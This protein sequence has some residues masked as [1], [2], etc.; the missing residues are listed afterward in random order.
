M[1][2]A[3]IFERE[4]GTRI[5]LVRI[6]G[7]LGWEVDATHDFEHALRLFHKRQPD[8]VLLSWP[9]DE[10]VWL[11]TTIKADRDRRATPVVVMTDAAVEIDAEAAVELGAN[12]VLRKPVGASA[13]RMVAD[14]WVVDRMDSASSYYELL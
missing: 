14:R 2:T 10:G 3:L 1:K 12:D 7:R 9:G 13:L 4:A 5:A 8:L 11:L 6:L